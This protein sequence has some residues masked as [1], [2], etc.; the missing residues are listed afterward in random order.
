MRPVKGATVKLQGN[1]AET[2]TC[3][4]VVDLEAAQQ[5]YFSYRAML[6]AIVWQNSFVIVY[7]FTWGIAQSSRD[8]LQSGVSHRCVC[9]TLS[10]K[11]GGQILRDTGYRCDRIAIS[12]DMG[13]LRHP[14]RQSPDPSSQSLCSFLLT[15]Q[16]RDHWGVKKRCQRSKEELTQI[17]LGVF[18]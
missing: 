12:R 14:S 7:S 10:T 9:V 4:G 5:R 8:M 17:N 13:R 16:L 18:Q 15:E 3:I 1:T 11:G 6:V 2:C